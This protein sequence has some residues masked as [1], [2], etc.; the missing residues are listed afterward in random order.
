MICLC[1]TK[2]MIPSMQPIF[3]RLAKSLGVSTESKGS[4]EVILVKIPIEERNEFLAQ[5]TSFEEETF[6]RAGRATH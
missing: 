2:T 3:A 6:E 4:K 1:D 5:F